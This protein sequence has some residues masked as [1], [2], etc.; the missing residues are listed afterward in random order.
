MFLLNKG[1]VCFLADCDVRCRSEG[2]ILPGWHQTAARWHENP[3]AHHFPSGA[4]PSQPRLRQSKRSFVLRHNSQPSFPVLCFK[5]QAIIF[6]FLLSKCVNKSPV[7]RFRVAPNRLSRNGCWTSLWRGSS[8]KWGRASSGATACG[9][10]SSSTKSR[11][12]NPPVLI[13]Q[14]PT[15]CFCN[16]LSADV[17]LNL[18]C[19]SLWGDECGSWWREQHPYLHRSSASSGLLWVA[20]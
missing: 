16:D 18:D 10:N 9:T 13:Q 14:I 15:S 19:R 8:L 20:R 3:A 11:S 2:G 17:F 12:W 4:S 1:F 6:Q 7:T 5:H